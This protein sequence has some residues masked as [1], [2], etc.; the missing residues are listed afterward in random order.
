MSVITIARLSGSGGDVIA[1]RVAEAMGYGFVDSA[2]LATIAAR[3]GVSMEDVMP[4]DEKAGSPSMEWLKSIITPQIGK[5]IGHE[6]NQIGPEGYFS[7]LKTVVLGLA[8]QG[9]IVIVGRGSQFILRETADAFHIRIIAEPAARVDWLCR[10]YGISREEALNRIKRSDSMRKSFIQR[11]FR[12]DWDD[13]FAYDM[14]INTTRIGIDEAVENV[15]SSVNIFS[16]LHDYI[17][18]VRDRRKK[19]RRQGERR[20]IDRR[21][22]VIWTHRDMDKALLKDGRPLRAF[23]KP[24]RRS[25]DRRLGGRRK[26]DVSGDADTI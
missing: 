2:L 9:N 16:G 17:P 7:S 18:G 10:Y 11:Y 13:Q 24:D 26:T 5:I 6:N 21:N 20:K 23:S 22:T 1:S 8:E 14:I 15:I 25:G 12:A 4:F 19:E 3:V